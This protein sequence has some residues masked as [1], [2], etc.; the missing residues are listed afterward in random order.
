MKEDREATN[1]TGATCAM[2]ML[3]RQMQI[4]D[5]QVRVQFIRHRGGNL[6][7]LSSA[8]INKTGKQ[9]ISGETTE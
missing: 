6:G 4:R 5:V 7:K 8:E 2:L 9:N 1:C 3:K